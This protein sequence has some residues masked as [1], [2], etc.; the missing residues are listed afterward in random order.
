MGNILKKEAVSRQE[1]WLF[2]NKKLINSK[3]TI[4]RRKSE[5]KSES[6]QEEEGEGKNWYKTG[7]P[8]H[9]LDSSN[10]DI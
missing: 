10:L 8:S 2:N 5:S 4:E 7:F 6:V 3:I 1:F 9:K